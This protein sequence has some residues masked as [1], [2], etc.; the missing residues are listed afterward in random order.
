VNHSYVRFHNVTFDLFGYETYDCPVVNVTGHEANGSAFDFLVAKSPLTC[1][2][3]I[4]GPV[5]LSQDGDVGVSWS[6]GDSYAVLY[7]RAS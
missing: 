6:M 3:G 5:K 7:V 2:G 4:Q 1:N